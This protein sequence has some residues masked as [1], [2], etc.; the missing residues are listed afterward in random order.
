ME[1]VGSCEDRSK[2]GMEEKSMIL[3]SVKVASISSFGFLPSDLRRFL[4]DLSTL[5]F[6][7]PTQFLMQTAACDFCIEV[8]SSL[9]TVFDQAQMC[10]GAIR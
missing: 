4:S 9:V 7:S 2:T 10:T 3:P 5:Y 1:H 8:P 6:S